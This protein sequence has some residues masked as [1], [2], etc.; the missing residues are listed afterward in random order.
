MLLYN[1][2]HKSKGGRTLCHSARGMS[3]PRRRHRDIQRKWSDFPPWRTPKQQKSPP[4]VAD[5][6]ERGEGGKKLNR[7]SFFAESRRRGRGQRRGRHFHCLMQPLFERLMRVLTVAKSRYSKK[8]EIRTPNIPLETHH[9]TVRT[10]QRT[11]LR[12]GS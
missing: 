9:I 1:K 7:S 11:T 8:I 5:G 12:A 6:S 4:N 2:Q 10:A 3:R